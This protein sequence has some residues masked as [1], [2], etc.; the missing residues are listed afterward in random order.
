MHALHGEESI[1]RYCRAYVQYIMYIKAIYVT[2][3]QV[4]EGL[5]VALTCGSV[6][7]GSIAGGGGGGCGGGGMT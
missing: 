6:F 7:V 2:R 3:C 4:T 5:K 1:R